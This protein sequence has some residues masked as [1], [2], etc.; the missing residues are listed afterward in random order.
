MPPCR[1]PCNR[2]RGKVHW[3][4]SWH[5]QVE[6]LEIT[7]LIECLS[8]TMFVLAFLGA[9]SGYVGKQSPE[10]LVKV[11]VSCFCCL[12]S[13]LLHC[14]A[15][16]KSH[17]LELKKQTTQKLWHLPDHWLK[18]LG[19]WCHIAMET[20]QLKP[21]PFFQVCSSMT[22]YFLRC[23]GHSWQDLVFLQMISCDKKTSFSKAP[24]LKMFVLS[25][26]DMRW[27]RQRTGP[28]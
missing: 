19:R 22:L 15:L 6:T 7:A 14:L 8:W 11:K 1:I 23:N 17:S 9:W 18:Y 26:E 21:W 13:L 28:C 24:L 10:S 4:T 25:E 27:L 2:K 16:S 12:L 5:R 3:Q 20:Q